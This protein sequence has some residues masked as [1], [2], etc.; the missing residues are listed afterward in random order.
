MPK[1]AKVLIV[2]DD[3]EIR[4]AIEGLLDGWDYQ[5]ESV[6]DG[7]E[8]LQNVRSFKPDIILATR[9]LHPFDG[10]EFLQKA[11]REDPSV[12]L[13]VL[14]EL[15][16]DAKSVKLGVVNRLPLGVKP[17]ILRA[18][19]QAFLDG[20][21]RPS[22]VFLSYSSI[23]ILT[24]DDDDS[25][26]GLAALLSTWGYETETAQDGIEG[27]EKIKSF[28]PDIVI[29][30]IRMP[31][32]DGL[33]FFKRAHAKYP[34]I[35][36]FVWTGYGTIEQAVEAVKLG[37]IDYYSKPVD[38]SRFK[39]GLQAY[40]DSRRP[41]LRA[42]LC[43]SSGDKA[44][45]RKLYRRLH[46]DR[47]DAWL[48]N[49]RLVPGQKWDAEIRKAICTSDVVIVCLS[50]A[51]VNK[52]GYVQKEIKMALDF[53]EEKPDEAIFLIPAKLEECQIPDRLRGLQW[54]NLFEP[55][56]YAQLLAALH[57]RAGTI[58]LK[59]LG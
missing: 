21:H 7:I 18:T 14:E 26:H 35:G 57:K 55:K 10:V 28:K 4:L 6:I 19:L 25:R 29:T 58:P 38:V 12:G 47:I 27:L 34:T 3:E 36:F 24:V 5:T 20:R 59:F 13:F 52:E 16:S 49:K 32:M 11:Q 43:H 22:G 41:P 30:D 8:G 1:H 51:S 39:A 54:V 40:L 9:V 56:G 17:E 15:V 42:F 2:I 53:A 45:V 44:T 23:R 46:R 50:R 33:Q 31:R 48:D 37:A